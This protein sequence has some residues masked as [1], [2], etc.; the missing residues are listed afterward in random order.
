MTTC[1]CT[2]T[3]TCFDRTGQARVCVCTVHCVCV[4]AC[5]HVQGYIGQTSEAAASP[6]LKYQAK[7]QSLRHHKPSDR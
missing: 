3:R 2:L 6:R 5:R 7:C 1:A 4:G